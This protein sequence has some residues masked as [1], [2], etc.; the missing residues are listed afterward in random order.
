MNTD[1][2]P[3]RD[4][5]FWD[6]PWIYLIWLGFLLVPA[7]GLTAQDWLAAAG[8][9]ALF[10][11]LYLWSFNLGGLWLWLSRLAMFGL[12]VALLPYNGFANVFFVYAGIPGSGA[13]VRESIT[14]M[15]LTVAASFLYFTLHHM[16]AGYF[17]LVALL[18]LGMGGG[19]LYA[20]VN[21]RTRVTIAG[22][23]QEIQR[24]AKLAERERIARDL[25]DLLGHTLSLIA[26]KAE[27]AHKLSGQNDAR[28]ASEMREVAEVA[29]KSLA[30][31][32]QAI[33][34]LRS[35][36]LLE[37]VKTADTLLRAAGLRTH[38]NLQPLPTLSAAQEQALSQAVL[39]AATNIVRHAQASE[40]SITVGVVDARIKVNIEDNG[41]GGR[42]LP[43]SG[44][45][46]MRERLEVVDGEL[47][48]S[49]LDPGVRI[50][51]VLPAPAGPVAA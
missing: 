5:N 35:I 40:A 51:A 1:N 23:D 44:L 7:S 29:R 24:L 26:I 6:K 30:D 49:N 22:K 32:R 36:G 34:G 9:V 10:V 14:I 33:A 47:Q 16:D 41:R 48:V 20:E 13:T 28:A 11:P 25:H 4:E 50:A 21:E 27:L 2:L 39:E 43:G 3:R 15:I 38:L 18:V 46:G 19:M 31:V 8:G 17:A 45:A 12:G 42:I 37:A